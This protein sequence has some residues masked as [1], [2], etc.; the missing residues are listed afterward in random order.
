MAAETKSKLP[1][2][3]GF[4]FAPLLAYVALGLVRGTGLSP[5]GLEPSYLLLVLGLPAVLGAGIGLVSMRRA[6]TQTRAILSTILGTVLVVGVCV[7]TGMVVLLF[8]YSQMS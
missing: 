7:V 2:L 4:I 8:L 1:I 3:I 5:Q 6:K